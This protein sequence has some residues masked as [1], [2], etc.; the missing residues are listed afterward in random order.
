MG[1]T[2]SA[3]DLARA[4]ERR[5]TLFRAVQQLFHRFDV[6]LTPTTTSVAPRLDYLETPPP[7]MAAKW[8]AALYP[9]NLSG[10]PALSMPIGFAPSGLPIGAQ[11]IGPWYAE[12]Q[13]LSVSS[14]LEEALGVTSSWPSLCA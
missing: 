3:V 14:A 4:Q 11:L 2:W 1:R 7:G 8:A 9:F 6:L 13:L 10:H 5:T 12:R